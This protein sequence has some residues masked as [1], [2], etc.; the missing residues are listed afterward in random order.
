MSSTPSASY[1]H[2]VDLINDL[3]MQAVASPWIFVILFAVTVIDGFFP[4]VPSETVLV[5]AAAVAGSSGNVNVLLL[6]VCGALGAMVGDNIAY[7]LGRG[8]GTERFSWMRRAR[9]A[10]TF[11]MARRA[12][13]RGGSG[14]ILGARYV[15]V[16][17]VA[18]NMTAG[19]VRFPWRRFLPLSAFG[20][21][22]WAAYSVGIG[23]LAGQ[24]LLGQPL[25][26][27]GIGVVVALATGLVIDRLSARRRRE[28]AAV[29]A[30]GAVATESRMPVMR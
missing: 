9:V 30:E 17:R 11:E 26:S 3:I 12:L 14:L 16:G 15:P 29:N 10:A 21:V 20:G 8:V 2:R 24:W 4:P 28:A 27:A 6:C 22:L 1:R 5:A 18:V 19:A 23:M 25:L 7:A 13:S